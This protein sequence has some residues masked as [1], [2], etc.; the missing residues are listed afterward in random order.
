MRVRSILFALLLLPSAGSAQ[1]APDALIARGKALYQGEGDTGLSVM[2]GARA[3]P[4]GGISC[5]GCHGADAGGGAEV[6]AGPPI[7]WQTL[8]GTRGYTVQALATALI[9]GQRPDGSPLGRAMPRFALAADGDAAALAVYLQAVPGLQ[10]QGVA[11][12]AITFRFTPATPR[13]ESFRQSFED[14]IARLAPNGIFGRQIRL[15]TDPR[16]PAIASLGEIQPGKAGADM[17]DLFPLATLLGDEDPMQIRGGFAPLS[18]QIAA[19]IAQAEALQVL[20]V[21]PIA[22]RLRPLLATYPGLGFVQDAETVDPDQPIFVIGADMLGQVLV[23]APASPIFATIDDLALIAPPPR[24]CVAATDPRPADTTG[25]GAGAGATLAR[26][27]RV[28]AE[29]LVQA[30][31]N[32]GPDCTQGRLM[33]GFDAVQLT[34]PGWP[35]LDYGRHRL[36]GSV[37]AIVW[38]V[39]GGRARPA[40]PPA[41]RGG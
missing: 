16:Q 5:A 31:R 15:T 23:T 41:G 12:D 18:A 24:G 26:Y 34:D 20:S 32:C 33:A 3:V 17:P 22:D 39:C 11:A 37:E 30:V 6:Q 28:A 4:A 40:D 36:T 38:Q 13:A 8:S 27:G 14:E 25:A 21:P 10:R 2:L 1:Q 7:D 35:A 9:A 19:A 29:V